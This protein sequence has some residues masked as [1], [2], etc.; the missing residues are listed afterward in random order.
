MKIDGDLKAKLQSLT[1]ISMK[2]P[3]LSAI[4]VQDD[5]TDPVTPSSH[6]VKHNRIT[7]VEGFHMTCEVVH[8][9]I[10]TIEIISL[11]SLFYCHCKD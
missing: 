9:V 2:D 7:W 8:K 1:F 6:L 10:Q 4:E 5:L 11:A 3:A